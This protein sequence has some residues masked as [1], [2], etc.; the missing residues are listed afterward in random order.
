M[1][2]ETSINRDL[3]ARVKG[4]LSSS[5]LPHIVSR[6]KSQVEFNTEL[7]TGASHGALSLRLRISVLIFAKPC[8]SGR[9]SNTS[10]LIII[11]RPQI[12]IQ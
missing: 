4:W 2:G 11:T 8:T 7:K 1:R 6:G 9:S 3:P 10:V 5:S 12:T